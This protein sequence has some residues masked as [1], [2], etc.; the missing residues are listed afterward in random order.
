VRGALTFLGAIVALGSCGR[1]QEVGWADREMP[2]SVKSDTLVEE[3]VQAFDPEGEYRMLANQLGPVLSAA[4]SEEGLRQR[5]RALTAAVD[6]AAA[7]E[8]E[9]YR[10]LVNRREEIEARFAEAEETGVAIP[11]DERAQLLYNYQNIEQELG[12]Y[13]DYELQA[14]DFKDRFWEF[15]LALFERMRELAPEQVLEIDRLEELERLR[16]ADA[17]PPPT[18]GGTVPIQQ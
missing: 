9:F 15:K 6:E 12:R 4:M 8:S 16:P 2:D 3:P 1:S 10:G 17:P 18:V 7:D 13:R 14:G 11:D 5:Y